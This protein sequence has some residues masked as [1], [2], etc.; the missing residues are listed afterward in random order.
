MIAKILVHAE[1]R[2]AAIRKMR[3]ALDETLILGIETNLD[4]QYKIMQSE[5]FCRGR[6]DT[7]F[8]EAFTLGG[9][10]HESGSEQ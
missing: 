6:A 1:N 3:S 7:S 2:E 4:F 5:T 9:K 10:N 8:I